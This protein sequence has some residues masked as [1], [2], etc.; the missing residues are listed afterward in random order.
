LIYQMDLIGF[1]N[2][3]DIILDQPQVVLLLV[4]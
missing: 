3:M 1:L 2:V 4:L